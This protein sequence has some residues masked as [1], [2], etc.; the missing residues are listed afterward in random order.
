MSISLTVNG[1]ERRFEG[2]SI[3]PLLDV[4]RQDFFLTGVKDVCREGFC[5][6]CTVHLDGVAVNSCLTPVCFVAQLE[7]G[8]RPG[9]SHGAQAMRRAASSARCA[10][11]A[12][13]IPG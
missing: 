8:V 6:A 3:T 1:E 2:D 7:E 5:G 13:H 12:N 4:L 10:T 11:M 9:F